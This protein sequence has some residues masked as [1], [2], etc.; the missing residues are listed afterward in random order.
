M[1][2]KLLPLVLLTLSQGVLAQQI[3]GAGSQLQQLPQTP[4]P[5]ALQ[6]EIRIEEATTAPAP[7]A[8][9]VKVLVK[10]LRITGA[11]VFTQADLVAVA[12]FKP[13]SELTL[14]DLQAMAA[15]ITEYYR[16]RGYFVARAYLPAQSVTDN[17][18]TIAVAEGRYGKVTLRNQSHLS[19]SV[20][21]GRLDGLGS[22]DPITIAPL[23][24]RLLLLSDIPGVK[25]NSTLVPGATPGSS[26]LVV[27]V[28]PG[29]RVTGSID[30]D[31]A[32][33]PYT[34]E[35]RLGA[36]LNLNNPLGRGDLAS[37]RL[38]T[39]GPGLRYGR[40]SYQMPFGRFAA[41]VAYSKLDYEL[42]KQFKVLGAHGTAEVASVFG[43]ATLVRSRDSNLYAGLAYED[44]T[45]QDRIDLFDSVTDKKAHVAIASLYGNHHDGIG[46][47]GM[48]S[49]FLALSAGS[50]DIQ[51]PA[52]LAVDATS[53][54]TNG[55]YSKLWFNAS[56]V[57]RITDIV[58]VRAGVSGQ[59]ASKNLDP[60]EKM[61]L[62]GMDGVRGYPQGEAFGDQGYLAS[63]EASLLLAGLS[64]HVPG[65]VH[66]LGFV[67]NGRVTI[68]KNPWYVGDN[69][70][71]LS[72]AGVGMT[73]DDP[74]NFAVRTYYAR[75]LGNEDAMSAPD[76][77]GRFW[78]QAIKYF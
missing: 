56:R 23:E 20:A 63:V 73:W 41:G 34:G 45:F 4:A 30:A 58:S 11:S 15:R 62:G 66:L 26:D 18:V 46:G 76:K 53:A 13:G 72:S 78:I 77:S 31:N 5:Q 75:K 70:R 25:V 27:D 47:G 39:S 16:R 51:T 21:R 7:G 59:V 8:D 71:T 64:G 61:V 68:N 28:T 2:T 52:A 55:S 42:G 50:L 19:D 49:F 60:S 57:Q 54:R 40:A 35:Y 69:E 10:E 9:S 37:L 14:P 12:Q 24:S 38:L 67:D 65:Q 44:R 32:G 3:P 36:T 74:G 48:N 29:R 17:V 1:K 22:G 43:T 6:P 33:N